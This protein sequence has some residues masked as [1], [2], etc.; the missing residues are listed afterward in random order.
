MFHEQR[1]LLDRICQRAAR[2][3]QECPGLP[4]MSPMDTDGRG[5]ENLPLVFK[6]KAAVLKWGDTDTVG[7]QRLSY[8]HILL[9][10]FGKTGARQSVAGIPAQ[11]VKEPERAFGPDLGVNRACEVI[12]PESRLQK[13][14][15]V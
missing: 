5:S 15:R 2:L 9:S 6:D 1:L 13:S 4:F 12:L 3:I 8:P 11:R 7:K 14:V 10:A